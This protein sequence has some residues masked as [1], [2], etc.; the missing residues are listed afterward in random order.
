[1]IPDLIATYNIMKNV[2]NGAKIIDDTEET[3]WYIE[4]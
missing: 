1:M 3:Y 2:P 4:K